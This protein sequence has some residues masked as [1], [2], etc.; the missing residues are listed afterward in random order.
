[1]SLNKLIANKKSFVIIRYTKE[2]EER[3]YSVADGAAKILKQNGY[4]YLYEYMDGRE[5]AIGRSNLDLKK[6]ENSEGSI[7]IVKEGKIYAVINPNVDTL[8]NDNEVR[9][10]LSKY[11]KID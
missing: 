1:M 4:S 7:V 5:V 10:W 9:N 3:E 11:I 8:K 6:L 2:C